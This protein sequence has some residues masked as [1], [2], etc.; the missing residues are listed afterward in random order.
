MFYFRDRTCSIFGEAA[1]SACARGLMALWLAA[2]PALGCA[3]ATSARGDAGGGG[4]GGGG[5]G[6]EDTDAALPIDLAMPGSSGGDGGAPTCLAPK[7]GEFCPP[8]IFV[9]TAGNDALPG[10][11]PATAV[12]HVGVGILRALS[13]AG[14]PCLVLIAAGTYQEQVQLHE[15]VNLWGGYTQ[16]FLARDP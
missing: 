7:I 11:S 15:D 14:A 10:T 8:A 13:C 16:D 1:M 5:G 9:S 4:G 2:A 3:R 6:S 12:R